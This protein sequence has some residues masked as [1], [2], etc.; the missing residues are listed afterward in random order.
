MAALVPDELESVAT[1]AAMTAFWTPLARSMA[2][3][4]SCTVARRGGGRADV[5]GGV[6]VTVGD[7]VAG[8]AGAGRSRRRQ[9]DRARLKVMVLPLTVRVS[10]SEGAPLAAMVVALGAPARVRPKAR[11]AAVPAPSAAAVPTSGAEVPP[12][13]VADVAAVVPP[14]APENSTLEDA[15]ALV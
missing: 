10:P 6:A 2:F 13:V 15:V 8:D 7:D 5:D 14:A 12:S 4:R 9:R 3:A 1:P 11:L